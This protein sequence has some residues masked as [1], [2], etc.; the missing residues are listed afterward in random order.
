MSLCAQDKVI[1]QGTEERG[2]KCKVI[3]DINDLSFFLLTGL[4]HALVLV[5]HHNVCTTTSR[6]DCT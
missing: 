3:L 6:Y 1:S 2:R 5:L 4:A